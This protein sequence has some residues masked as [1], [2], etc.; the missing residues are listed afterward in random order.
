MFIN[1]SLQPTK[2]RSD[3]FL[4]SLTRHLDRN[5]MRQS[6]EALTGSLTAEAFS[7]PFEWV[8]EQYH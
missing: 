1:N 4:R 5:R 2:L 3:G 7:E 6:S 8:R